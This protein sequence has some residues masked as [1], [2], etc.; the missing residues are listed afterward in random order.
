MSIDGTNYCTSHCP[1]RCTHGEPTECHCAATSTILC[2]YCVANLCERCEEPP[3]LCDCPDDGAP[4]E[5][6]EVTDPTGL[7]EPDWRDEHDRSL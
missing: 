1:P 6:W 4:Q 7:P 5:Q 2:D 3:D